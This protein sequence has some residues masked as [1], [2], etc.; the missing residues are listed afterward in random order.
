ML[1]ASLLLLCAQVPAVDFLEAP[2]EGQL[3]PRDSSNMADVTVSGLVHEAGWHGIMLL[4]ERDGV[5]FAL[6]TEPL[7]YSGGSAAFDVSVPIH[8]EK[9]S[10]AFR[11]W[12]TKPNERRWVTRINNVVAGDVVLIQGQS[13]AVAADGYNEG[14]ANLEQSRWVRSF[15]TQSLNGSHAANNRNWY[16][17]DGEE[18]QTV[19]CI[20]GWGLRMA[21]TLV[22][23]TNVPLAVINGGVGATP[24][25]MHMRNDSNPGD[26]SNIYG[27]LLTRTRNAGL[28]DHVRAILWYQGES[29]A[30]RHLN[31]LQKFPDLHADWREDYPN[32][33]QIYILQVRNG[34]GGP[35][36]ELREVQRR[37]ADILPDT[38]V[39]STTAAPAH[40][41]CHFWYAG[42]QELGNRMARLL[43]RDLYGSGDTHEIDAPNIE[44]AAIVGFLGNKVKLTFRDPDDSLHFDPAAAQDFVFEDGVTVQSGTVSGNTITLDLSGPTLSR[45][46]AYVGHPFDGAWI[47]NGRGIGALAFKVLL[48]P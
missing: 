9:K 3:Y 44:S 22:D 12:L 14:L 10:Y 29:D 27:R 46:I 45:T 43:A 8:A 26:T 42:Y 25:R 2:V 20:G 39:M 18:Q 41:S 47:T 5:A 34:C 17:A 4:V 6:R 40:D 30:G 32:V 7:S 19:G 38:Q 11:F 31:Y 33:E 35:T 24:I 37:L 23:Q 28:E 48:R 13:N 21:R 36:A 15:G 1:I 16:L